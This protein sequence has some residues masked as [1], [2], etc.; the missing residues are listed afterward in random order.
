MYFISEVLGPSYS[1]MQKVLY[2]V[3]MAYRKLQ[4]YFQSNNIIIALS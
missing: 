3:L 1:E 2:A 4:H